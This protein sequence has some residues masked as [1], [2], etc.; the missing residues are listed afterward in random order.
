[1]AVIAGL[2]NALELKNKQI[3]EVKIVINGAEAASISTRRMLLL[4]GA[5]KDNIFMCDS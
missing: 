3:E 4:A 2:F 5:P 1:M